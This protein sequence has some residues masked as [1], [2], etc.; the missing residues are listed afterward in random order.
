[1]VAYDNQIQ[2]LMMTALEDGLL[3]A[4]EAETIDLITGEADADYE[5]YNKFAGDKIEAGKKLINNA[6]KDQMNIFKHFQRQFSSSA[7]TKDFMNGIKTGDPEI[8]AM[9]RQLAGTSQIQATA[10][11]ADSEDPEVNAD[12]FI[13]LIKDDKLSQ[14]QL[15]AMVSNAYRLAEDESQQGYNLLEAFGGTHY[16]KYEGGSPSYE[17][18]MMDMNYNKLPEGTKELE[19]ILLGMHNRFMQEKKDFKMTDKEIEV[20]KNIGES[21]VA[22]LIL[23]PNLW[24]YQSL[25]A[26]DEGALEKMLQQY[27]APAN[28]SDKSK[29]SGGNKDVDVDEG[30]VDNITEVNSPVE[31]RGLAKKNPDKVYK[32]KNKYYKFVSSAFGGSIKEVDRE[33][34]KK[35][36][37]SKSENKNLDEFANSI[38]N[39]RD[40]SKIAGGFRAN[41]LYLAARNYKNNPN[42]TTKKKLEYFYNKYANK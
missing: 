42:P 33:S 5:W 36:G 2:T 38:N 35:K 10:N 37:K 18:E 26:G 15:N 40:A 22:N 6:G 23:G 7:S 25:V 13:Q 11:W 1:M 34:Q 20:M 27:H 19:P 24:G 8:D 3:S 16:V 32:F 14:T 4:D 9:A 12:T 39:S 41:A 30:D 29:G 28:P 21:D 17:R 31:L